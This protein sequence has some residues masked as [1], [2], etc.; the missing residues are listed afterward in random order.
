MVGTQCRHGYDVGPVNDQAV[1]R[2]STLTTTSHRHGRIKNN[3]RR[4]S[5]VVVAA[6][7]ESKFGNDDDDAVGE[8]ELIKL[9][10][11]DREIVKLSDITRD[12]V[13]ADNNKNNIKKDILNDIKKDHLS[14]IREESL[15]N[16]SSDERPWSV[17]VWRKI[18]V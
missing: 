10:D 1:T 3:D 12:D 15:R 9:C 14:D 18:C 13:K 4:R 7:V 16:H 2:M 17:F 5:D 6:V 8:D 11:A